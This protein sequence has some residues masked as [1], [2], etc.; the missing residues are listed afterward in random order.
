MS[1]FELTSEQ[2]QIVE[3]VEKG[4]GNAIVSSVAG[5]GKTTL[6]SEC[7]KKISKNDSV[8]ILAFNKAIVKEIKNKLNKEIPQRFESEDSWK[9]T[10]ISTV[11]SAGNELVNVHNKW[12]H[13]SEKKVEVN[14]QYKNEFMRSAVDE[15]YDLRIQAYMDRLSKYKDSKFS[16]INPEPK[17]PSKRYCFKVLSQFFNLAQANLIDEKS[18]EKELLALIEYYKIEI[19]TNTEI[20]LVE[21][22]LKK[23][24]ENLKKIYES[25]SVITLNEQIYFPFVYDM[26]TKF[27]SKWIFI[28]ECQDLSKA[29][30]DLIKRISSSDARY[31]FVGDRDQSINGFCGADPRSFDFIIQNF[32]PIQFNLTSTFRCDKLITKYAQKYV[33]R[34][35]CPESKG[36]GLVEEVRNFENLPNFDEE[37]AILTRKKSTLIRCAIKLIRENKKFRFKNSSEDQVSSE[38]DELFDLLRDFIEKSNNYEDV[39]IQLSNIQNN[40]IKSIEDEG[41]SEKKVDM[42]EFCEGLIEL[43]S[44]YPRIKSFDLMESKFKEIFSQNK[45]GPLLATI[46]TQKG[47]QFNKV[48]IADFNKMPIIR[49][50]QSSWQLKEEENILYVAVTRAK[51]QLFLNSDDE[52]KNEISFDIYDSK[53]KPKMNIDNFKS[54]EK[55]VLE[56]GKIQIKNKVQDEPKILRINSGIER[57]VIGHEFQYGSKYFKIIKKEGEII[58]AACMSNLK[59]ETFKIIEIIENEKNNELEVIN[60][61]EDFLENK[62]LSEQTPVGIFD[63]PAEA[64]QESIFEEWKRLRQKWDPKNNKNPIAKEIF[65]F[66]NSAYRKAKDKIFSLEFFKKRLNNFK[67]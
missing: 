9:K 38:F 19:N 64:T 10:R 20:K 42:I 27:G 26:S 52:N 29:Q 1:N 41:C 66:I 39:K 43:C 48:L 16:D 67:N 58:I 14:N 24:L 6:I 13:K 15:L 53:S 61:I 22:L 32:K 46:H 51:H 2:K 45:E 11:S 55:K 3:W 56:A 57:F 7:I 5:S 34:I 37:D 21:K 40:L 62:P 12:V 17:P 33:P 18:S 30:M 49:P 25:E 36:N 31:L 54:I 65:E 44:A 35:T 23:Y 60:S 4:S 63:N 59:V 50:N 28:D 47:K 8:R